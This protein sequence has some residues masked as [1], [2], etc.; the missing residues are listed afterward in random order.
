ME[1]VEATLYFDCW[2]AECP[3]CG[4]DHKFS[5]EEID[6]G[7]A[8]LCSECGMNFHVVQHPDLLKAL[9][10]VVNWIKESF[11]MGEYPTWI[12]NDIDP[13]IRKAKGDKPK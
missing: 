9:T 6:A 10:Y 7:P 8:V 5:G 13:L 4:M 2:D 12:N 3:N 11:C 1:T